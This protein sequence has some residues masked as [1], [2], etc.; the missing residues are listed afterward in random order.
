[1]AAAR[2]LASEPDVPL[3]AKLAWVFDPTA[4]A[5]VRGAY[6][7]R[8]SAKTRTFA[9]MTAIWATRFSQAGIS[10]VILCGRK[11]Q[12]SLADSSFE[13]IK[14]AILS[15]PWLQEAFEIGREYIRT[16]DG[17]V[18]Y[19]FSGLD[20]NIESI[21]SK[22]RILLAWVDE[23]EGVSDDAW[24]T[25]IPT[26]REEGVNGGQAWN[27]E[28]WVTWNP[29]RKGS[30]TDR[31]FRQTK[32]ADYRIVEL[33]WRDNPWFPDKL[34]RSRL[35]DKLHNP[36]DYDHIWEGGYKAAVKGAYFTKQLALLRAD[37]RIC[38]VGRDPVLIN[39][40]FA[41]IGGTGARADNFVFWWA[42]FVAREIRVLEHYERQGQPIG[43]HLEW[44]RLRQ[45]TPANTKIWLP[46]DGD[47][48][49]RVLDVSYRSGLEA[50][51]YEVEVIENQGRGAAMSRVQS[52]RRMMPSMVFNN[53]PAG[54]EPD[55]MPLLDAT[56]A[57][58]EALAWYHEK[59]D[60]ERDIGLGPDHDW[61]SHT[62]DA[63]GLM[64][65]VAEAEFRG[66]PPG[67]GRPGVRR[68][69]SGMAA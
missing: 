40:L 2:S 13:E 38:R 42:Q 62:A 39:R 17:R 26:L 66:R 46:H 43:A 32:S 57:G 21:K 30:A 51:G 48:H 60:K 7:G 4:R 12:N 44:M 52:V 10:G 34:N 15:E 53:G 29:E 25:L 59:W 65:I 11:L 18:A 33:N 67:A 8:G 23:A 58:R 5:D 47:T 50:A 68:R 16:R 28:L 27:A 56:E 1:M 41:D 61:A 14:Q 37:G 63:A 31:R 64:S 45:L 22:S 19:V 69:V 49:D 20:H 36:D 35:H 24:K 55:G 6:G 9:K 3:P 54:S